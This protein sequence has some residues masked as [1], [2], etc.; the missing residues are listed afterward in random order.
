M[1]RVEKVGLFLFISGA[2]TGSSEVDLWV[3]LVSL[4]LVVVGSFRFVFGDEETEVDD[5]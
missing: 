3:K 2:I 4:V 1:N 5:V